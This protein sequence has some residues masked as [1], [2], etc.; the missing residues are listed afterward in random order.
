MKKTELTVRPLSGIDL[1]GVPE[2]IRVLP[3][4]HVSS[5]KGDFEVDDRDIAGIIRQFKARRLD[6]VI[7]YEHQTLSDVQAPAAGWIKDLYPG[8]DAL[9]ARVEWT[10]KGR[11]YI[12]NK[13]YRYLSPVV[14]V[15]KA[16][17]HAAV[18]HSAAL[19]NTPAITGMFAIINSDALSIEEEEEPRM[20]LSA[21]IELLGL[22]EGTAEE[23]VLKRIKELTQQA[24]EE[25]QGGQEGKE[26]P[27]K[28]GTQLVANKTVLD[29][30]GLPEDARTED[31]TARIMAFKAG[32]SA[33]QRRVAELEKQAASQ[34]AEELV[35][36]AMKDGKLS[37]AQ[38]EWAVAYAL[39][40]PKGFAK[41]VEKA[42]VVVPMG[43][44]A[45]AA[46]ERKQ[47][48]VDW[49]ILKNQG[50]TEEDLK[51]YGGMEDDTDGE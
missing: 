32:D 26:G 4:G 10:K 14:L 33:L 34:K 22:E 39:S 7:D 31:V 19:T 24:A 51:K 28:E 21:L 13:E 15:K 47:D 8:E 12:A 20:E 41:F 43:K 44:T 16:D 11:E 45:F 49:R 37:P 3:K 35:G 2:V 30:L 5:T 6:L 9:M 42:P 40:D 46:D 29:L 38:K 17:Q 50:V 36:L 23:D 48:G 18:F 27:A 25:G 1:S